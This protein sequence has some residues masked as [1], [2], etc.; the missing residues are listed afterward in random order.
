[1]RAV[2]AGAPLPRTRK[3]RP[4]AVPG[5]I[6]SVTCRPGHR[7]GDVGP[8]RRLRERHRNRHGDVVT[9]RPNDR[10]CAHVDHDV[11]VAGGTTVLARRALA[12]QPDA[13]TVRDPGG[14]LV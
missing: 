12:R 7:D 1:M 6:C 10:V 4:F 14:I 13:R 9:A 8:E 11:Q 5:G 3:V 2:S